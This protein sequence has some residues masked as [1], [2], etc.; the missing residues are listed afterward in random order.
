[1]RMTVAVLMFAGF[2]VACG[3][4]YRR[5]QQAQR[6]RELTLQRLREVCEA[7]PAPRPALRPELDERRPFAA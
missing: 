5:Y 1:M 4:C 2:G 6:W 3:L 7:A